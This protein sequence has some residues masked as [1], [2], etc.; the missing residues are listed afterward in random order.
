MVS[1][2]ESDARHAR[3]LSGLNATV[4][5]VAKVLPPDAVGLSILQGVPERVLVE[6]S[7]SADLL[8]IG[9]AAGPVGERPIGPVVRACLSHAH[10]P[11]VVV[12]PEGPRGLFRHPTSARQY[13]QARDED[14]RD[15]L[16]AGRARTASGLTR[17][18]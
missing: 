14:Q 1:A 18:S 7:A 11:V 17:R 16:M 3:A 2:G 8:V 15:L 13:N 5:A 12:G 10:C 4:S 6:Q 9:S